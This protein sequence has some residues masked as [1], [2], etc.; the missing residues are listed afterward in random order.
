MTR[1]IAGFLVAPFLGC[2]VYFI[3]VSFPIPFSFDIF[4]ATLTSS[5][6]HFLSIISSA[7]PL[8]FPLILILGTV[9]ML[10]LMRYCSCHIAVCVIGA[11][12]NAFLAAAIFLV[13]LLL[14]GIRFEP[15]LAGFL[16]L[17]SVIVVPSI[18]A[19]ILFWFIAVFKNTFLMNLLKST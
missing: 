18:L 7:G 4:S 16:L 11:V 6:L 1:I 5:L 14:T 8:V 15:A 13:L 10:L 2:L 3:T 17:L 9:I 19:G 12:T